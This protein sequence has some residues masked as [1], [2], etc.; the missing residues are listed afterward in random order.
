MICCGQ[1]FFFFFGSKQKTPFCLDRKRLGSHQ[2]ARFSEIIS[3]KWVNNNYS[4]N[5]AD[6]DDD[7]NSNR[8]QRSS[9][10]S[11][12]VYFTAYK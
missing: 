11:S 3:C 6:D 8:K 9:S 2:K 1:F 12:G 5:N 4:N 7:D 10:F